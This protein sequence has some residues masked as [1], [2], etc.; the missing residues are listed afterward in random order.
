MLTDT[1]LSERQ[2]YIT[3]S[4]CAAMF[5]LH[6]FVTP[7]DLI[8]AKRY[9]IER[10]DGNDA[11]DLGTRLEP[12]VMEMA[13]ERLGD[14]HRIQ[15]F[16]TKGRLAATL[17]G[18][19]VRDD[20][21]VDA[22]TAGIAGPGLLAEWGADGSDEVPAYVLLQVQLQMLVMDAPL[23]YVA[24]LLGG[25]G[26][27]MFEVPRSLE[28]QQS[29]QRKADEFW[30]VIESDDTTPDVPQIGTLKRLRRVPGSMVDIGVELV[31]E[32]ER[33]KLS[34]KA[35]NDWVEASKA[36][37]LAA[38]GNAEGATAGGYQITYF[39]QHRRAYSVE[40]S[41]SRVLRVK[42]PKEDK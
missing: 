32:F 41:T 33:A 21:P 26:F 6:P 38:L 22:K 34:A 35:A 16:A 14:L 36:K 19:T 20:L 40:E 1:Q 10:W 37:L 42:A 4:E 23:A 25:R 8:F 28:I 9:G 15:Q 13:Q 31:D 30:R 18:A 5:G 29:I 39:E 12:V 11:T 17:D 3:A 24:A 2:K 7:G 27:N